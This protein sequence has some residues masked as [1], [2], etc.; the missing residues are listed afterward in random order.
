[1]LLTGLLRSYNEEAYMGMCL[2]CLFEFC[3]E[4][5]I[6]D[7][8]STDRTKKIATSF[9][10]VTWL[11]YPGG[12]VSDQGHW[13]HTANQLNFALPHCHGE[14]IILQDVDQVYCERAKKHLREE[15]E[16]SPHDA[17]VMYCIHYLGDTNHY[18]KEA[19]VGPSMVRLW[20]NG[21][22]RRFTGMV[23]SS[24]LSYLKWNSLATFQ[25]ARFHYGN[26][27]TEVAMR[28]AMERSAAMPEDP[29]YRRVIAHHPRTPAPIPWERCDPDC[30]RCWMEDV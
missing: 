24:H 6:S 10:K 19:G 18:I 7:G 13:N 27:S 4:V 8:G 17:Y 2:E 22:D 3:D 26:I 1:M 9:D 20:R 21:L 15:L 30:E 11:D 12:S 29:V 5:V 28:K 16:V 25:G 23:H 14:W